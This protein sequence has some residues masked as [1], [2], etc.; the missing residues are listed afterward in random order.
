MRSIALVTYTQQPKLFDGDNL[1]V[2]P[3][4]RHGFSVKVIPWDKKD[5][6]WENFDLVILRSAW[7]YHL[8]IPE[9]LNWLDLLESRKVNLWNPVNIIR[10]NMN[11]KYLLDLSNLGIHIIP[12]LLVNKDT[13]NYA[14]K[15]AD[16][17]GWEEVVVKPTYGASAYRIEKF[18]S[19]ELDVE[20]P[21]LQSIL[22]ESDIMIQPFMKEINS[23]GELSFI[24][25][26]KQYSHAILKKP[27]KEEF[28]SQPEFG[29]SEIS[30]K[31]APQLLSQ[32]Q[33]IL[34]KI[35]SPLLY[36]RIDGV[37]VNG[38]FQLME[39]ELIEPYLFFEKDEKS[40]EKFVDAAISL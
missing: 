16:K 24:F 11:K 37:D 26:D 3:F 40:A 33:Q 27:K 8:R 15:I 6:L 14:R 10:W 5:I 28:R 39:L 17:K 23:E 30:I 19:Q 22:R 29:G 18:K 32:A 38:Q 2:D 20:I 25:F 34:G 12:T 7:D 1:L 13:L 36:A 9:F 31:P 35:S 4:K 21:Q